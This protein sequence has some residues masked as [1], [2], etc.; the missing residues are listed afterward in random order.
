M[1][2]VIKQ[3]KTWIEIQDSW[4]NSNDFWNQRKL[5][6]LR[7]EQLR[8]KWERLKKMIYSRDDRNEMRLDEFTIN[9]L[10]WIEKEF[11]LPPGYWKNPMATIKRLDKDAVVLQLSY[12][13]DNIRLEHDTRA[14]RVRTEISRIIQE[15]MNAIDASKR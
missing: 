4:L 8:L 1:E 15:K 10:E 12:Y 5:W 6:D 9:L 14:S 11:K 13:V 3:T 7:M 2:E